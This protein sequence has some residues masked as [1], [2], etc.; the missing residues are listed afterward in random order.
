MTVL[1]YRT[2]EECRHLVVYPPTSTPT[3]LLLVFTDTVVMYRDVVSLM[4]AV[5]VTDSECRRRLFGRQATITSLTSLLAVAYQRNSLTS[6]LGCYSKMYCCALSCKCNY[7][8]S[9]VSLSAASV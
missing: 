5:T 7:A 1:L 8:L 9:A 2:V 6:Y 4:S 3:H